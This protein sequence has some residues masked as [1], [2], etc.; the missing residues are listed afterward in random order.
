MF[1]HFGILQSDHHP[2]WYIWLIFLMSV[3]SLAGMA[4]L[5]MPEDNAKRPF[6]AAIAIIC[7][8]LAF[9]ITGLSFSPSVK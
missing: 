3:G 2:E 5:L 4:W 8:A 9:G 1:K 7:L 6:I